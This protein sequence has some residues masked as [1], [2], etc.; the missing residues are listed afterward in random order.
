MIKL[1]AAELDRLRSRRVFL[2]GLAVLFLALVGF[3]VAVGF[4]VKQPSQ[5]E[6]AQARTQFQQAQQEYRDNKDENEQAQKDCE[7]QMGP[8]HASDCAIS[9]PSWEDYRPRPATF[10][11][12]AGGVV[13]VS[14]ILP[15]LA[16]LII[17]AS[18]IGAEYGSGA[19]ANWLSF[20]PDRLKVYVSKLGTL[21]L[22]GAI[23]TAAATALSLA[24]TAVLV[25]INSGSVTKLGDL[26][27]EGGRG[28]LIVTFGAAVGFALALIFRHTVA[29]LGVV[30]GYLVV[31]FV[32]NILMGSIES[33]QKLKPWLVENN[34][35]AVLH[36]GYPYYDQR[37]EVTSDGI[38]YNQVERHL[39]LGHGIIYLAV[40]FVAAVLISAVIF[41]RRDVT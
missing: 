12:M 35:L 20:I 39:S 3:Q 18:S 15:T 7:K 41:R 4:A 29:A 11:D 1:F 19:I 10:A 32:L 16:F 13:T 34:L 22:T 9:E 8:A 38:M 21:L 27:A 14:V 33:M 25:K 2:I 24:S 31:D 17:G 23:V 6:I 30:L 40:L 36:N 37:K 5:A 26:I 28:L